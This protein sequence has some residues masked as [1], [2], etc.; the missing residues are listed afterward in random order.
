MM[1]ANRRVTGGWVPCR[2]SVPWLS[3]SG[4]ICSTPSPFLR[5]DR[6]P[7]TYLHDHKIPLSYVTVIQHTQ[8]SLCLYL[9]RGDPCD[10]IEV[11]IELNHYCLGGSRTEY[12]AR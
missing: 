2:G 10:S 12:I 3:F 11:R 4:F 9:K 1:P 7:K 8:G 6:L 5:E